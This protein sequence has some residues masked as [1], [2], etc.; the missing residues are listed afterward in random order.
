[1]ANDSLMTKL[2]PA[3]IIY[4]DPSDDW[5]EGYKGYLAPVDFQHV[6][7]HGGG[8]LAPVLNPF[9]SKDEAKR[10]AKDTTV[11]VIEDRCNTCSVS[12][13]FDGDTLVLIPSLLEKH[14]CLTPDVPDAGLDKYYRREPTPSGLYYIGTDRHPIS[15][16]YQMGWK[17]GCIWFAEHYYMQAA[18]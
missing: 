14:T 17:G 13:K 9:L 4:F 12:A 15:G 8:T 10:W 6:L 5:T 1:M 18:T 3:E 11:G 16:L 7:H 2:E